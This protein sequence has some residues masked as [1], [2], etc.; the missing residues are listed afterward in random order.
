MLI[1][2]RSNTGKR[3]PACASLTGTQRSRMLTVESCTPI[4][5]FISR[6]SGSSQSSGQRRNKNVPKIFPAPSCTSYLTR[7][8][9]NSGTSHHIAVKL[10]QTTTS[11]QNNLSAPCLP[12]KHPTLLPSQHQQHQQ[13]FSPSRPISIHLF[14]NTSTDKGRSYT[15]IAHLMSISCVFG[16]ICRV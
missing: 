9:R 15:K 14:V 16:R 3:L 2:K 7:R 13:H 11:P 5:R 6:R 1:P 4:I 10:S 8:K 12:H